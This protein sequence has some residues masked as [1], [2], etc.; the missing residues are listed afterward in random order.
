MPSSRTTET[1]AIINELDRPLSGNRRQDQLVQYAKDVAADYRSVYQADDDTATTQAWLNSGGG[2]NANPSIFT[3][4]AGLTLSVNTSGA[5]A[6]L[7]TTPASTSITV[8]GA[9]TRGGIRRLLTALGVS[10]T[11]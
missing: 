4:G 5:V 11:A 10:F 1:L 8:P 2:T 9:T 6:I 7:A 3:I